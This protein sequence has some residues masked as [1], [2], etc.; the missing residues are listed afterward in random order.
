[1][2]SSRDQGGRWKP[3]WFVGATILLGA[4]VPIPF[5]RRPEFGA[6]GPD[7]F[8]H[9][10]GH[11]GFAVTVANA[12]AGR[13]DRRPAAFLAVGVAVAYGHLVE[14][15]QERVPGR[16]Y[17]TGDL[18]AGALGSVLGTLGWLYLTDDV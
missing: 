12:L 7:K 11:G 18:V 6:F 8:L 14:V 16:G 15:L 17:E 9:L 2:S 5:E 1:M 3:V 13:F 10:V 4:L